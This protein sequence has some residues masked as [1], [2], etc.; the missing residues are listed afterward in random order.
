M[1]EAAWTMTVNDSGKKTQINTE[2]NRPTVHEGGEGRGSVCSFVVCLRFF[3]YLFIC[4]P[5]L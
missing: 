4:I 5:P 2:N 3:I 1:I